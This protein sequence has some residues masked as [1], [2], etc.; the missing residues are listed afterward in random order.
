M[1]GRKIV[2]RLFAK[3]PVWTNF[4]KNLSRLYPFLLVGGSKAYRTFKSK[5]LD[6]D[7]VVDLTLPQQNIFCCYECIR[8]FFS[9]LREGSGVVC[10]AISESELHNDNKDLLPFHYKVFKSSLYPDKSHNSRKVNYPLLFQPLW[11]LECVGFPA[12]LTKYNGGGVNHLVSEINDFCEER[13]LSF[14]LVLLGVWSDSSISEIEKLNIK[15][16]RE[17]E[18][19]D[20]V[21][22]CSTRCLSF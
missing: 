12:M 15:Y 3:F 8:H 13:S 21:D 6:A 2:D 9:I 18:F 16:C 4:N 10:L 7:K 14:T 1:L 11:I 5:P 17:E 19:R 20:R 22:H